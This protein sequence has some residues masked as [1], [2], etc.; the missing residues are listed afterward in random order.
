MAVNGTTLDS[1]LKLQL[2]GGI[3]DSGNTIVRSKTYS[4]V[5][6]TAVNDDVYAVATSLAAMQTLPLISIRRIEEVELTEVI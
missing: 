5:K 2:D 1:K 4:N 3:D 6:P